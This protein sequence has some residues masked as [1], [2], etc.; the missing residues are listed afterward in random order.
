[1]VCIKMH[2]NYIIDCMALYNRVPANCL[3]ATL[4]C[5]WEYLTSL[6]EFHN[7]TG[8]NVQVKMGDIVLVHDDM[9]NVNWKL[10]VIQ[11]VIK[12]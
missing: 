3:T 4:R 11:Q 8:N 12:G 9:P 2:Q 7:T 5:K 6:R 10:A 1:M